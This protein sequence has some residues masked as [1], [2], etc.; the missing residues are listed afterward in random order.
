MQTAQT[1]SVVS[2]P[3]EPPT[4]SLPRGAL[5]V[6]NFLS[7]R[8]ERSLLAAVAQLGDEQWQRLAHRRVCHF[9]YVFNY[10]TRTFESERLGNLPRWTDRV[11]ERIQR[12]Q[13]VVEQIKSAGPEADSRL[14]VEAAVLRCMHSELSKDELHC[15]RTAATH[16]PVVRFGGWSDVLMAPPNDVTELAAA[17][18]R[19][20]SVQPAFDQLTINEYE[21]GVGLRAHVDTH[22]SFWGAIASVSLGSSCAFEFRR[23]AVHTKHASDPIQHVVFVPRCS[24]LIMDGES[25]YAWNHFIPMRKNDYGA[26]GRELINRGTR[27]SLTFRHVRHSRQCDCK[28]VAFCDS[29]SDTPKG[30]GGDY[31]SASSKMIEAARQKHRSELSEQLRSGHL[32]LE[33]H[34]VHKAYESIAPHFDDTRFAIW[35]R[36]RRFLSLLDKD[37]CCIDIGCGNGKHLGEMAGHVFKFGC[38]ACP[39]LMSITRSKIQLAQLGVAL[40]ENLPFRNQSF[41]G[42]I[43]IAVLHHLS[44]AS[45]RLAA[46]REMARVLTIGGKGIVYVWAREQEHEHKTIDRWI[47]L[48]DLGVDGAENNDYL[49]P[50]LVHVGARED[51][52][53]R[54]LELGGEWDHTRRGVK[55]YRYYHLF[56]GDELVSLVQSLGNVRVCSSFYERSNW[57]CVFERVY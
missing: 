12:V 55:V 37:A 1:P 31:K 25:R 40:A 14:A 21:C 26:D 15:S 32:R 23:D 34:F 46:L 18:Q 33:E 8:E 19:G 22:S 50:W 39:T 9:G 57:G 30:S 7:E 44:S 54:A 5:L 4:Q 16:E 36:V 20:G 29:Q 2:N 11:V 51:W 10:L 56:E 41:D 49:A 43:C 47:A 35:P 28:W 38:D 17:M 27:I 42:A 3:P 13:S 53:A 45:A 48:S 52:K 24:L 6:E